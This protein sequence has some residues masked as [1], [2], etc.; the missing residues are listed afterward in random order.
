MTYL[1]TNLHYLRKKHG[2]SQ[3]ELAS[4]LFMSHQTVSNHELGKSQP[5]LDGMQKYAD[6]Y[7]VPLSD[8]IEVDLSKKRK[9]RKELGNVWI[10]ENQ[11]TFQ[12]L[13][14]SRGTYALKDI[15]KCQIL[16]ED[17]KYHNEEHPFPVDH[18]VLVTSYNFWWFNRK[19]YIG[20]E[21]EL[22]DKRKLYVYVSNDEKVQNSD[23]FK[24]YV[25][26]ANQIK[27]EL[28]KRSS[29]A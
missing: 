12:I 18:R 14:G 21:I 26:Q 20:L 7:Q 24:K 4:E 27:N 22:K 19:V 11:Q 2:L 13:S 17:A 8:L 28:M 15:W 16:F 10:D 9:G 23:T 1:K 5:D 29:G 6:F 25:H 3:K